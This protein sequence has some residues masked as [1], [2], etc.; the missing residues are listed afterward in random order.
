[1]PLRRTAVLALTAAACL[2]APAAVLAPTAGAVTPTAHGGVSTL[3]A[4]SAHERDD[5]LTITVS[6]S[7]KGSIDGTRELKCHPAGGD[8]PRAREACSALDKATRWGKDPFAPVAKDTPCTM[9]YGGPAVAHVTGRWAGRPVDAAFKRDNGCEI[10]RWD[11]LV[12]A[13]PSTAS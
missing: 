8:H 3:P 9:Q 10:S 2:V 6:K 11:K 4:P 1:M 5:H 13:L 7:G 12:P